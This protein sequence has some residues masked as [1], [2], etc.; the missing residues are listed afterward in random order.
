MYVQKINQ[1]IC[2]YNTVWR[3]QFR[4]HTNNIIIIIMVLFYLLHTNN[5]AD[6][7][8]FYINEL[9][10][11]ILIEKS[12]SIMIVQWVPEGRNM[13]TIKDEEALYQNL[14][15]ISITWIGL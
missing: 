2:V 14:K 15:N 6:E 13:S 8:Y 11:I 10:I 1:W 4:K 12:A 3:T 9:S 7:L 5:I